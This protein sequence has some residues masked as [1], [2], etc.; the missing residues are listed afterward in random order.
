VPSAAVARE[1]KLHRKRVLRALTV[2]RRRIIKTAPAGFSHNGEQEKAHGGT[3]RR[4]GAVIGL[5]VTPDHVWA[6]VVP[7][8][9]ADALARGGNGGSAVAEVAKSGLSQYT[10]LVY[11]RR[12][13]RL[14]S[15]PQA[16]QSLAPFGPLEAFWSYLQRQLRSRGGIRLGRLNL[17]LAE[18]S[19]RYNHRGLSS[20]AQLQELMALIQP[21]SGPQGT[22]PPDESGVSSTLLSGHNP[23]TS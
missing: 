8:I 2:L 21:P 13:I 4:R 7:G 3:R 9:D 6:E 17:Y 12:L 18:Y 10:A 22:I 14:A 15:E 1:T 16:D 23:S 11:R 20:P 5:S 19:W